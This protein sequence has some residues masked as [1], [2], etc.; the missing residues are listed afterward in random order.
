[1]AEKKEQAY[2]EVKIE[3]ERGSNHKKQY[4]REELAP[5]R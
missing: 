3:R 2:F 5:V 4:E 1:M